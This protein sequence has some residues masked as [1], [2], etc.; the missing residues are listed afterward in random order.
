MAKNDPRAHL[1]T[2]PPGLTIGQI[3]MD[4]GW[5][6]RQ[7]SWPSPDDRPHRGSLF[8]L[9]GLTEFFE[10]Y[11]ETMDGWHR[12]GWSVQGFDWR[13]QGGSGRLLDNPHTA[14]IDR[15]DRFIDDLMAVLPG[16]LDSTPG[17]HVI[18]AHSMGGHLALRTLIE[19][20]PRIDAAVL[21]APMLGF[22]IG[23]V[24]SHWAGV[25]AHGLCRLGFQKRAAWAGRE[26]P[27]LP[28]PT[29]PGMS[30][31]SLLTHDF[32]RYLDESA[33]LAAHPELLL[34]AP[35]WGWLDAAAQSMQAIFRPGGLET[36]QMPVLML[37]AGSDRLVSNRAIRAAA[38]RLPLVR[39]F[40]IKGAYHELLREE[41]RYRQPALTAIDAFLDDVAPHR[42]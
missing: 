1:R 15:F 35:S 20:H 28:G 33:W 29:L 16:W 13:G 21:C 5:N 19:H 40:L 22:P 24:P 11:L 37:M 32:D 9:T 14:Y 12:Q 3:A 39:Q 4:D 17:P 25:I 18:V 42:A 2:H 38:A 41:D 10:K 7:F 23:P 30:R 34:G 26:R 27:T 6:L 8:F 31:K 36:V